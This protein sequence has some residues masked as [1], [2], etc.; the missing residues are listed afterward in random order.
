MPKIGNKLAYICAAALAS[1]TLMPMTSASAATYPMSKKYININGTLFT[2]AEGFSA[3]DPDSG[4]YTT[5]MPIWYIMQLLDKL[6]VA[7]SWNGEEW[8]L[9]IPGAT[10]TPL[11]V[12]S[13]ASD[14]RLVSVNNT[15]F[16]DPVAI[17]ANDPYSG[18]PT[19]YFPIWYIM[20]VLN[21]AGITSSWNGTNWNLTTTNSVASQSVTKAQIVAQ[22]MQALGMQPNAKY[23]PQ[24]DATLPVV[25]MQ[26]LSP[27]S[28]P[29]TDVPTSSPYFGY[30]YTAY[31]SGWV[32]PDSS[33]SFGAGDTMTVEQV[34]AIYQAW[35]GLPL[36]EMYTQNA[37]GNPYNFANVEYINHGL[38]GGP[39]TTVTA[40]MWSQMLNN[41]QV[42]LRGYIPLANGK[43]QMIFNSSTLPFDSATNGIYSAKFVAAE[44]A[45][46]TWF[47]SDVQFWTSG[48]Y[49][50]MSLPVQDPLLS[51]SVNTYNGDSAQASYN[52]GAT[53]VT[54]PKDGGDTTM[55][56]PVLLR[57]P[58]SAGGLG[59]S[60]IDYTY[61]QGGP[62]YG[63]TYP[64]GLNGTPVMKDYAGNVDSIV[65]VN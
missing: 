57:A 32:S 42:N 4:Q 3:V 40:S 24:Y 28:S 5:Y 31:E 15:S 46:T 41:I 60:A 64:N 50:Y 54:L 26:R 7:N 52:G 44:S 23:T 48:G 14:R 35:T 16:E 38:P 36:S 12:G 22:M 63:V 55:G 49:I 1:A 19:T 56:K 33:T 9:T 53:W 34:D 11:N 21:M 65:N 20:Q 13:I 17:V 2:S 10:P 59:F 39:D 62:F 27:T 29:W 18:N 61:D 30:D 51:I 47:D 6:G 58:A 37:F 25:D 8:M 43:Y 45:F